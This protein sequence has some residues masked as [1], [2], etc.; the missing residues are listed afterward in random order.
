MKNILLN[1]YYSRNLG[2][3]LFLK[4]LFDRYPNIKWE[5]LTANREY[6]VIF[7]KYKNVKINY[8]Y[9]GVQFKDNYFN[10][11]YKVNNIINYFK[12]FDAYVHIGGSIFMQNS[13]WQEKLEEREYI[14]DSFQKLKKPTFII[15]PNFGPFSDNLFKE[16]YE[17]LFEKCD[18]ICFRD[19][20][21]YEL[22]KHI[23]SV[24]YAPD[25]IFN[26]KSTSDITS[27]KVIGISLISLE[28]R[29]EL[30]EYS[31]IYADTIINLIKV[32]IDQGSHIRLFSFCEHEGDL[33]AIKSIMSRL[34]PKYADSI[35]VC[36]YDCN[37]DAFIDKFKECEKIIGSRFHSI[38]LAILFNKPFF[39]YLYSDKTYNVLLDLG[40]ENHCQYIKNITVNDFK[41]LNFC[42]EMKNVK[43][44]KIVSLAEEQLKILDKFL[45]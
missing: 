9:R 45:N 6:K 39:A 42:F 40:L 20:Y 19:K 8:L 38:I 14:I 41:E 7:Q 33:V 3:D 25:V 32:Y 17:E 29:K 10:L 15:G 5:L 1:A 4:I 18:D 36:N 34:G 12:K 11:F 44:F 43:N 22:F 37:I 35:E 27:Q 23:P 21:S 13:A 30:K 16:R 2:D 31:N 26:L 24:R 28:N